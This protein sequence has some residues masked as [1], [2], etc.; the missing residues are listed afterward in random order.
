MNNKLL[1]ILGGMGPLA[2]AEFLKTI[3]ECNVSHLEQEAPAC[4]L[5]SNPAFPDRTDAI[6]NG[7]GHV[8][9]ALLIEALET[10]CRM[11]ANKLVISCITSHYFLPAIPTHL[12]DRVI[13]LIDLIAEEV[14][15]AKRSYLLLRTIGARKATVFERHEQWDLIERYVVTPSEG[16]QDSIHNLIYQIKRNRMDHAMISYFERLL[17]G[18]RVD[19]F[20]AGCTEM[21]LL[22]KRLLSHECGSHKYEVVD[23]LLTLARNLRRFLED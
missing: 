22:T 19:G 1:G 13:S 12:R 6:L 8:F 20:I 9:L 18:Y 11:G 3:Y 17:D 5:Y 23:P 7:S 4:I 14:L 16:D 2:S 21:H 10:L 15:A